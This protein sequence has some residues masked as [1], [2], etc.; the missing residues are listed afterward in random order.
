MQWGSRG[1]RQTHAVDNRVTTNDNIRYSCEPCEPREAR[2][3]REHPQPALLP[4]QTY[5]AENWTTSSGFARITA[6]VYSFRIAG[7]SSATRICSAEKIG[8]ESIVRHVAA[9]R[10]AHKTNVWNRFL[11]TNSFR[12][13][14]LLLFQ[15]G[16]GPV[17][18]MSGITPEEVKQFEA[19]TDGTCASPNTSSGVCALPNGLLVGAPPSARIEKDPRTDL[20]DAD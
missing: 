15:S 12:V 2:E 20:P 14:I 16:L 13:L 18:R 1:P 3:G 19:P 17:L 4:L 6:F 11:E 9:I 7:R 5:S 10:S 8:A